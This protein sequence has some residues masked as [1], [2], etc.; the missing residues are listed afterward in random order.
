[1]LNSKPYTIDEDGNIYF[2]YP[3]LKELPYEMRHKWAIGLVND[4]TEFPYYKVSD[5]E[6]K[7]IVN[8]LD[9]FNV[10]S[11]I[12]N[13]EVTQN[14]LGIDLVSAFHHHM[15]E[16]RCHN[17]KTPMEIFK[18]KEWFVRALERYMG[19]NAG[20]YIS[21]TVLLSVL[22]TSTDA[23]AVSNFRP[24]VAKY[25]YTKYANNGS[26]LDPCMGYGGR[27]LGVWCSNIKEYVGVDPCGAT[28]EGNNNLSAKLRELNKQKLVSLDNLSIINRPL[29]KLFQYPFEDFVTDKKFDLVFTSPPYLD[30]ERYSN[31][32]TQ[33]W[34]RYTTYH[35]WQEK[36]Y[37][38]LIRK[39]YEYLKDGGYF[40]I[41]VAPHMSNATEL[42]AG[43][44]FK[45]ARKLHMAM[46]LLPVRSR[47]SD[48]VKEPEP[49][50]IYKKE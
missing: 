45:L 38:V 35:D 44:Y 36:F 18:N 20:S 25:I 13:N 39:S 26:V 29:I 12:N 34:K 50:Y 4:I 43:K 5:N 10:E 19:I 14:Q 46:S 47:N 24:T 21:R 49:I 7:N 15:W 11:I 37:K 17:F 33:S 2:S 16:V 31:E 41:N 23:Q 27:L 40:V 1:M 9:K 48:S 28:I 6:I 30:T 3:S 22:R 32:D 42:I 8:E